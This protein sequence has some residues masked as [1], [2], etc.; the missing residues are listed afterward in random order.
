MTTDT[1]YSQDEKTV[2]LDHE[3]RSPAQ[4]ALTDTPSPPRF[5]QLEDRM[6]YTARLQG[7]MNFN[8]G[9]NPLVDAA[10]EL[11][12]QLNQLKVSSGREPLQALNDRLAAAITA[13]EAHA[14]HQGADPGQV[15]SARYVLCSTLDEA[16]AT[17]AWGGRS[18][19]AKSSLLSRFHNETFG[20]EK[21][22]Q[23]LER[24]SHDPVKHVAMLEL[25]Y[26]CLSMGFEGK[27]R[28]MERGTT[29]LETVR[30]ALHRQIRHVRGDRL[31]VTT[32]PTAVPGG[33]PRSHVSWATWFSVLGFAG[34][35]A[36]YVG[37]AWVLGNE[38][39]AALQPFQSLAL[40][41]FLPPL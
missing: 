11:L 31:S 10:W 18:D 21:F 7:A 28:V 20:G 12:L 6:I 22:F 30:D 13:F 19:W 17:T 33:L 9:P 41:N 4:A 3:G 15:M 2:L 23:L 38:R 26:L 40:D 16:V 36:M 27:Y 5:E 24:L 32:P 29:Q 14:L 25:I 37:F 35:L 34:L 8:V 1:E 39:L